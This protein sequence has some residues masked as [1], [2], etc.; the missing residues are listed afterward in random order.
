[1]E[2]AAHAGSASPPRS[3]PPAAP[4]LTCG[5][6]PGAPLRRRRQRQGQQQRQEEPREPGAAPRHLP[7]PHRRRSPRRQPRGRRWEKGEKRRREQPVPRPGCRSSSAAGRAKGAAARPRLYTAVGG[8]G[9]RGRPAAQEEPLVA[10]APGRTPPREG[11]GRQA[12]PSGAAGAQR[13]A[14]RARP[15]PALCGDG[16]RPKALL[17]QKPAGAAVTALRARSACK[18]HRCKHPNAGAPAFLHPNAE[19]NRQNS[20]SWVPSFSPGTMVGMKDVP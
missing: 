11:R 17:R 1:M 19:Q 3:A 15:G 8:T 4:H 9:R 2:P 7:P 14:G 5:A 16:A 12:P 10:S 18:R 13:Y 20:F 6:G